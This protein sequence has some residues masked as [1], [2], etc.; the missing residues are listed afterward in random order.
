MSVCN[1]T[2]PK[3]NGECPVCRKEVSMD[4]LK[5]VTRRCRRL[6]VMRMIE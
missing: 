6:R 2:P 1:M 4:T 5:R 3:D